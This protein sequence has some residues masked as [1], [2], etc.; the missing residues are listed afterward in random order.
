[1]ETLEAKK[2]H[3]TA[4][5]VSDEALLKELNKVLPVQKDAEAGDIK[6]KNGFWALASVEKEDSDG[7]VV[8]IEGIEYNMDPEKGQFL[9]LLPSHLMRLPSGHAAEI[10][11][12]ERFL[13]TKIDNVPV[14]A[15]YFTFA[16]DAQGNPLDE[17]VASYYKRY[18]NNYCNT[19]SV[20]MDVLEAEEIPGAGYKFT[21]T[22]LFEVSC[23]SIPANN[24]AVGLTRSK[25][26][27]QA[28]SDALDA[29]TKKIDALTEFLQKMDVD[30]SFT[31]AFKPLED[32]LDSLE[33]SIVVKQVEKPVEKKDD[34]L[35]D[36]QKLFEKYAK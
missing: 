22:K 17:L 11:R 18:L 28:I 9:P 32:R 19:F 30:A 34:V 25:E 5:V 33:S 13:K 10:G 35:A 24:G 27:E 1:M 23:V 31:K 29:L 16:L 2:V 4:H 14:L 26:D 20:G 3:K 7:D 15:F 6:G 36:V 8:V 21:K 12:I